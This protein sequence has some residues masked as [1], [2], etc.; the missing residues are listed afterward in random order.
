MRVICEAN[1]P[2]V[3]M[4]QPYLLYI[5]GVLLLTLPSGLFARNRL[6]VA[7]LDE[8]ADRPR[9]RFGWLH[10]LNAVDLIR[11]YVGMKLLLA[12]FVAVD[13]SAPG[14]LTARLVLAITALLGLLMQHGF[15]HGDS[16]DLPAPVAYAVGLVFA[17]LPP[18]VALLA[19]PLGVM[20]ALALRN[21]GV[22]LIFAA[23]CT[24]ILGKLFGLS[25]TSI[26]TASLLLFL[27]ALLAG[28]FQRRL[29][30]TIRRKNEIRYAELR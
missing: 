20:A 11:A 3:T 6:N 24:A 26:G 18:Q 29:V 13:P 28:L 30:L 19:L 5:A 7:S 8:L 21:L 22:G 1:I 23:A 16:D 25:L 10:S 12:A 17:I 9:H 15:H 4:N 14:Q 2:S 27:P